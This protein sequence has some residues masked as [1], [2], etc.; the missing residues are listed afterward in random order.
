MSRVGGRKRKFHLVKYGEVCSTIGGRGLG[1]KSL[2][3]FNKVLLD[4]RL[5]RFGVESDSFWGEIIGVKN[6]V[7]E[8][9]WCSDESRGSY[10][11][12]VWRY[13]RKGWSN[14]Q[15]RL[16]FGVGNGTNVRF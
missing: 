6:G 9:G 12:S 2:V 13:I 10:G 3:L 14:F 8:G 16:A 4:K 15:D 7:M 5:W 1:L 11:V